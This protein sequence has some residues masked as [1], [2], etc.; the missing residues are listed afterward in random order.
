MEQATGE[1]APHIIQSGNAQMYFEL[2]SNLIQL[3]LSLHGSIFRK[4][5]EHFDGMTPGWARVP[6][7]IPMLGVLGVSVPEIPHK[8]IVSQAPTLA[9]APSWPACV[10]CFFNPDQTLKYTGYEMLFDHMKIFL[11]L[12]ICRKVPQPSSMLVQ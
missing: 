2:I 9:P 10:N 7:I 6:K 11:I 4:S 1:A 3:H 5:S 12:F 8:A